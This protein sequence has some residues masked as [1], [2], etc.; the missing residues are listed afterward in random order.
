MR[1]EFHL[2]HRE[3]P[4]WLEGEPS[5]LPPAEPR[6]E[7]VRRLPVFQR[8]LQALTMAFRSRGSRQRLD[9]MGII[10]KLR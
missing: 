2:L 10:D 8:L 6:H 1:P 7:T 9:H 5:R 3:T 4:L